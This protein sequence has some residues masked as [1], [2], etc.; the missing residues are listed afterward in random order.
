MA[1]PK[2]QTWILLNL[3][4]RADSEANLMQN[5]WFIQ[6]VIV[7]GRLKIV[8]VRFISMWPK[9]GYDYW[10]TVS[11]ISEHTMWNWEIWSKGGKRWSIT[12]KMW[13][14]QG[15]CEK[16]GKQA[17]VRFLGHMGFFFNRLHN[18]QHVC[19]LGCPAAGVLLGNATAMKLCCESLFQNM[20]FISP[21]QQ[22]DQT[23]KSLFM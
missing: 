23:H 14:N 2:S 1:E 4:T 10:M 19:F 11:Y 8:F 12:G 22:S 16:G 7:R 5:K 15:K 21:K 20:L 18:M 6:N 13:Q 3:A 9:G 17:A